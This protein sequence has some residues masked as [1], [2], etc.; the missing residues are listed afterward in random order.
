MRKQYLVNVKYTDGS[1]GTYHMPSLKAA[2]AIYKMYLSDMD[3]LNV[4]SVGWS[5]R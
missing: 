4:Q 3:L 5:V 1:S 2:K